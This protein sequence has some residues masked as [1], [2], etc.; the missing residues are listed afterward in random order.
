MNFK[1]KLFGA[2]ML[3]MLLAMAV[4]V[5]AQQPGTSP[6]PG[7]R[8]ATDAYPG[9]DSED[10]IIKPSKKKPP[11]FGWLYG[12]KMNDPKSQLEWCDECLKDGSYRAGRKGLDALVRE[13]PASVEAPVAQLKLAELERDHYLDNEKAFKEFRYLIDFYP[14]QCDYDAVINEMYRLAERLREDGKKLMFFRF[15]NTV[16]VRRAY[17]ALILRSRGASF[18]PKA[19]ITVAKLREDEGKFSHAIQVYE[20]IRN[21]FPQS[22]QAEEALIGE[23]RSRMEILSMFEYNRKRTLDTA[24]FL[25]LSI[26]TIADKGEREEFSKM[27]EKTVKMIEDEAYRSAKFYDS[28]TRTRRSAINAYEKYLRDYPNSEHAEIVR[29]RIEELKVTHQ[30]SENE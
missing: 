5:Y 13:W 16:D 22:P 9:F 26:P 6:G 18:A 8:Y 15:A 25:K 14:F 27:Y 3:T 17:E 4:D 10:E 23:A 29:Q 12:P 21:L 11:I 24:Q 19:M 1:I 28:R 2:A 7:T 30:G 20:N